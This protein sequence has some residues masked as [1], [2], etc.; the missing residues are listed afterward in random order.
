MDVKIKFCT[1][2]TLIWC[3]QHLKGFKLSSKASS[4]WIST[5]V[6]FLVFLQNA[7]YYF[8]LFFDH[9]FSKG[10]YFTAFLKKCQHERS[11]CM[12]LGNSEAK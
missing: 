3:C 7:K 2:M 10:E 8:S 9:N 1:F 6:L 11:P 4:K 5:L 12:S